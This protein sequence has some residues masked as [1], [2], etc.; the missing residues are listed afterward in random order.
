MEDFMNYLKQLLLGYVLTG[1]LFVC[2][3]PR[4]AFSQFGNGQAAVGVL[5]PSDFTTRPAGQVTINKL[6]GPNGVQSIRQRTNC[7]L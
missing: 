6:N 5:G 1:L 4:V 7:S 2:V 3:A